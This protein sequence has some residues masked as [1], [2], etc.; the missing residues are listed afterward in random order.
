MKAIFSISQTVYVF[1]FCL[2]N[3]KNTVNP[4][5]NERKKIKSSRE[6]VDRSKMHPPP[7]IYDMD[8]FRFGMKQM[9]QL[10]DTRKEFIDGKPKEEN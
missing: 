10:E 6:R 3:L 8:M 9:I 1:Y 2:I 4:E 7:N 5:I